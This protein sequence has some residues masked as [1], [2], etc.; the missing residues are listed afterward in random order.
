MERRLPPRGC[1]KEIKLEETE[2]LK[3][4]LKILCSWCG[5]VSAEVIIRRRGAE[6]VLFR[7]SLDLMV[8]YIKSGTAADCPGRVAEQ[9]ELLLEYDPVNKLE[10]TF[11]NGI[12][13][14]LYGGG[15]MA[16]K[17]NRADGWSVDSLDGSGLKLK[18]GTREFDI[19]ITLLGESCVSRG[20]PEATTAA[21]SLRI[22]EEILPRIRVSPE[23]AGSSR[24]CDDR[25]SEPFDPPLLG[26]DRRVLDLKRAVRRFA[27]S[28]IPVLIEGESGTGKEI[29]AR[30]IHGFS[31]RSK[32]PLVA[33]NCMEVQPTLLRSELFGHSKGAFTGAVNDRKG[34]IESAR[35]G[36][37]FLDE[38]GDMPLELQTA[39]LRVI[40]EGEIRRLGE[41]S[42]RT[43]DARFVF[44]TNRNIVK[45]VELGR[46]RKDLF[47]RI[48]G[49]RI[50]VPPL[51]ERR[52]DILPLAS[53][54]LR[55]IAADYEVNAPRLSVSA[56]S[57]L[58]SY[59]WPGNVRELINEMERLVA[60]Y[61]GVSVIFEDML[62]ERIRGPFKSGSGVW[63]REGTLPAE[64]VK[65][66]RRMIAEE[67]T[68]NGGNR[69]KT[70]RVL[71]ISRQG[72]IN[73]IRKFGLDD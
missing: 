28:D 11:V 22:L 61:G 49:A 66:E 48:C 67:L 8:P 56:S 23:A 71:G 4:I 64:V 44:A 32:G 41:N 14:P 13:I 26:W 38:I 57:A 70:A 2:I 9:R 25:H 59:H 10:G 62:S 12:M 7:E 51:R 50:P 20:G 31:L 16:A 45:D 27:R 63:A 72:L 3:E 58:I 54:F 17:R 42:S 46:F 53:S 39:M 36:T 69:S 24:F 30:N 37:L 47:F 43:V 40:Q 65:L 1:L 55:S 73:K 52:G 5:A 60:F 34:L 68:R 15:L 18:G 29:I 19:Q 33:V 35:G 21:S 6:T